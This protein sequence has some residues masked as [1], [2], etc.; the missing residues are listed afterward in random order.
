MCYAHQEVLQK[1]IT[2][3]QIVVSPHPILHQ[4]SSSTQ[5]F[6]LSEFTKFD[7]RPQV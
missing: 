6:I 2:I 4:V 3:L 5:L 1:V 7:D